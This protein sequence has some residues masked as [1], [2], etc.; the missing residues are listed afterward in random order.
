MSPKS[1][2]RKGRAKNK[3]TQRRQGGSSRNAKMQQRLSRLQEDFAER[4]FE[5]VAGGG[6]VKVVVSGNLRL[7]SVAVEPDALEDDDLEM[8]QE[9][10]VAAANNALD[11][12]SVEASAQM[13]AIT[14]GLT[15]GMKVPGMA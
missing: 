14:G 3:S 2:H 10:I 7:V 12:A 15:T 11:K 1:K 4:E 5:D 9:M 8:V 6:V 13:D